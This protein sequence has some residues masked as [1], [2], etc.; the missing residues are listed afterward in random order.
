MET[1]SR[2]HLQALA[3]EASLRAKRRITEGGSY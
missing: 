3:M 1:D 2:E